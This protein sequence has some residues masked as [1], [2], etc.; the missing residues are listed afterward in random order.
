MAHGAALL[1]FSVSSGFLPGLN[2]LSMTITSDD[3]FLEAVRLQGELFAN[4]QAPNGTPEPGTLALFGG[5]TV[6]GLGFAIKRRRIQ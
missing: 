3:D 4:V 1:N 6:T 2:T 5:L